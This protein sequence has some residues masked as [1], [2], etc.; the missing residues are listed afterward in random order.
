MERKEIYSIRKFKAYGASLA[1]I[2][3]GLAGVLAGQ[4]SVYADEV[5]SVSESDQ[6]VAEAVVSAQESDAQSDY[7]ETEETVVEPVVVSAELVELDSADEVVVAEEVEAQSDY[8]ETEEVE[9]AAPINDSVNLPSDVE[10]IDTEENVETPE[11][12]SVIEEVEASSKES[13]ESIEVSVSDS[14]EKQ[15]TRMLRTDV[16]DPITSEPYLTIENYSENHVGEGVAVYKV[17]GESVNLNYKIGYTRI[18]KTDLELTDDAKTLGLTLDTESGYIYGQITLDYSK[19]GT[20]KI[21]FKSKSDDMV[22][23]SLSVRVIPHIGFLLY[24]DSLSRYYSES[25]SGFYN[26]VYANP[27][28]PYYSSQSEFSLV[29]VPASYYG[30]GTSMLRTGVITEVGNIYYPSNEITYDDVTA[31]VTP[32]GSFVGENQTLADVYDDTPRYLATIPIFDAMDNAKNFSGNPLA[33]EIVS[34]KQVSA[35]EGVE[36]ELLDLRIPNTN[37]E[38]TLYN[39]ASNFRTLY[40]GS[41][42]NA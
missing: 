23:A 5:V 35:S 6:P 36:V 26:S 31:P 9:G 38:G 1:L 17:N 28:L 29:N 30:D 41:R 18:E 13:S 4:N 8:L 11:S 10:V 21:G 16:G 19:V 25:S 33:L 7:I 37:L 42:N 32:F 27:L 34:F 24:D 12:A 15:V 2:G 14:G 20:Y 22:H 40:G 3:I 39:T